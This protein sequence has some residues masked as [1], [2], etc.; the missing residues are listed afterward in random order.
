GA[1]AGPGRKWLGERHNPETHVIASM[2]AVALGGSGNDGGA[3]GTGADGGTV[4]NGTGGDGSCVVRLFGDDY[5]TPDGTCIRDYIHVTDLARAHMLALEACVPGEH[6]VYNLGSGA[7]FSNLEVLGACREVTGRDIPCQLAPRPPGA[8]ATGRYWWHPPPASRPTW[9]G[10]PNGAWPRWSRT[11]GSPPWSGPPSAPPP[12]ATAHLARRVVRH[13]CQPQAVARRSRRA[14][15]RLRRPGRR[16]GVPAAR[17][18]LPKPAKRPRGRQMKRAARPSRNGPQANSGPGTA[19]NRKACGTRR[20]GRTLWG[21]TP[22]TTRGGCCRSRWTVECWWPPRGATTTCWTSGR[23]RPTG[24]SP[25][26]SPRS[27]PAA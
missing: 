24:R 16:C 3:S 6:R 18:S 14:E 15:R 17:T 21:N 11:P 10:V 23:T 8:P 9:A 27:G 7:G 22:T 26:R 2:L 5:P 4:G 20:A 19:R 12:T 25:C 13:P 1:Q